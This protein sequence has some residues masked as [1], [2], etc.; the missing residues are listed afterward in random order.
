MKK[1][2]VK[3][4]NN[5]KDLRNNAKKTLQEVADVLNI[6]KQAYYEY[7]VTGNIPLVNLVALACYFKTTP[8]HIMALPPFLSAQVRDIFHSL[9]LRSLGISEDMNIASFVAED[10]QVSK[11]A[12]NFYDFYDWKIENK[13]DDAIK[14]S[15]TPVIARLREEAAENKLLQIDKLTSKYF[16]SLLCNHPYENIISAARKLF[17]DLSEETALATKVIGFLYL[18]GMKNILATG[19]TFTEEFITYCENSEATQ[20]I[21]YDFPEY[22]DYPG[23]IDYFPKITY[24]SPIAKIC[25]EK[26]NELL[27]DFLFESLGYNPDNLIR[28]CLIDAFE[29]NNTYF[30]IYSLLRLILLRFPDYRFQIDGTFKG[31]DEYTIEDFYFNRNDYVDNDDWKRFIPNFFRKHFFSECLKRKPFSLS[32]TKKALTGKA[33]SGSQKKSPEEI[34]KEN[35]AKNLKKYRKRFFNSMEDCVSFLNKLVIDY[36]VKYEKYSD[37]YPQDR[38]PLE[39]HNEEDYP[40]APLENHDEIIPSTYYSY[41]RGNSLPSV[42]KLIKIAD[43]LNLSI[44]DLLGFSDAYRHFS[45]ILDENEE[46]SFYYEKDDIIIHNTKY[47][48]EYRLSYEEYQEYLTYA[49]SD[50]RSPFEDIRTKFKE[51]IEE[52]KIRRENKDSRKGTYY[53]HSYALAKMLCKE[54]GIECEDIIKS[55]Q[56]PDD[57]YNPVQYNP[58]RCL[59]VNYQVALRLAEKVPDET[60][61]S[62]LLNEY[63]KL[64]NLNTPPSPATKKSSKKRNKS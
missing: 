55:I 31:K 47:A 61:R 50:R 43:S 10:L 56:I 41:E 21:E 24:S 46:I 29:E 8:Q 9:G 23:Y 36:S 20:E 4:V 7:E 48:L 14:K 49:L 12:K 54:A 5:L 32:Y 63:L 53:T 44:D 27:E 13:E 2:T 11:G 58:M 1:K 39:F 51:M 17:P 33:N 30:D 3:I 42:K 38:Y 6:S 40:D 15:L 25:V 59:E 22:D 57:P 52:K 62:E 35:L 64:F 26:G 37:T 60:N 28:F 18:S 45:K 34:I 16:L 19:D